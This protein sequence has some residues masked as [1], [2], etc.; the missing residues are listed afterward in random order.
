MQ[1]AQ[2]LICCGAK[3]VGKI[4]LFAD[5]RNWQVMFQN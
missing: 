4:G 3:N 2:K 5:D 1:K